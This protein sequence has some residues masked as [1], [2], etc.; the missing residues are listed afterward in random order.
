[1]CRECVGRHAANDAPWQCCVYKAW[2]RRLCE[3]VCRRAVQFLPPVSN[4]APGS[5]CGAVKP[6][7]AFGGA[8]GAMCLQGLRRQSER[9]VADLTLEIWPPVAEKKARARKTKAR[10]IR[11]PTALKAQ[12]PQSLTSCLREQR[13]E[14]TARATFCFNH[15]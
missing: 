15:F 5:K 6:E 1:M 10:A 12:T 2:R 13:G 14:L 7:V 4:K 9:S 8:A 11:C 3:D